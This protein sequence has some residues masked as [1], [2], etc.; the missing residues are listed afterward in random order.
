LKRHN[1]RQRFFKVLVL[2]MGMSLAVLINSRGWAKTSSQSD[3]KAMGRPMTTEL[4]FKS[5]NFDRGLRSEAE[6]KGPLQSL[7]R[8]LLEDDRDLES[9]LANARELASQRSN[10]PK[11]S[12]K[13]RLKARQTLKEYF[14]RESTE[15]VLLEEGIE[16]RGFA[17]ERGE[18]LKK[19][20]VFSLTIPSLS[21]HIYWIVIDREDLRK[22]Y[23]YG[24]N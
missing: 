12:A 10:W 8:V 13:Q 11:D 14:N 3:G 21:D 24:F 16:G 4:K 5:I 18:D 19:N 15:L 1:S 9:P 23:V 17:P 20:W 2:V 6:I 7:E 22:A